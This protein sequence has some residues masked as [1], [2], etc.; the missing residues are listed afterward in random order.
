ML[1]IVMGGTKTDHKNGYCSN[2]A[3]CPHYL[4]LCFHTPFFCMLNGKRVEGQPGDCLLHRPGSPSIHGPLTD[5]TS[6]AND[7]CYFMAEEEDL[8]GLELPFDT[9]VPMGRAD[10][11][12]APIAEILK[13][14][15]HGDD[16][17]DRLAADTLY[18]MLVTVKRATK[19][20]N[21]EDPSLYLQFSR[22]RTRFLYRCGEKWTLE[23][24]AE[25]LGYSVSRFCALYTEF[26]GKSPMNDLLDMRLEMAR[27]LLELRVYKVE[28]VARLCGFSS[29]HYFSN[30]FK[31]RTGR[32]P[33][34]Y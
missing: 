20:K 18:R 32:A 6:F 17:S 4:L 22:A 5:D 31:R 8:K 1:R 34:A 12:S 10:I 9:I 21:R 30:F 23:R 19:E 27:Q 13:E 11:F 28:D 15:T 2:T 24:M 26:F 29:I 3:A 14:K 25:P 33:S 7:W 16:Y